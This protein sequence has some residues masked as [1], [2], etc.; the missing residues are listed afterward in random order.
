MKNILFVLLLTSLLLFSFTPI[1]AVA[2]NYTTVYVPGSVSTRVYDINDS[3][4]IVGWYSDGTSSSPWHGFTYDGSTYTTY[5]KPGAT[6]TRFTGIN[7]NGDITGEY[8]GSTWTGLKYDGSTWSSLTAGDAARTDPRDINDSGQIVGWNRDADYCAAYGFLYDGS[9]YTTLDYPG[10]DE[11]GCSGGTGWDQTRAMGIS[12]SG[13]I[14]GFYRMNNVTHG[15]T[16]EGGSYSNFDYAG[17]SSS[18]ATGINDMG[19][20]VGSYVDVGGT[21]NGYMYD[22][23]TWS[24]LFVP[25]STSTTTTGI[26]NNGV[27]VGNYYD[28]T[29]NYGYIAVVPEPISSTLFII[30]GA[31]LGFRL[32]RKKK[33][34]V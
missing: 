23:G 7:D 21:T 27:I 11:S 5:D 19:L 1:D 33:S 15:F 31:T 24:D 9:T 4:M 2:Y 34:I 17:S 3:G 30:G 32:N 18:Y 6:A 13:E 20:I 28:G 22:N 14:V 29:T 12:D 16:Y 25:G 8:I 26:N 10:T